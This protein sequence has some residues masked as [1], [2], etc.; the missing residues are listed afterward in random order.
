MRSKWFR[1][2]TT[3]VALRQKGNSIRDIENR[4]K[5]PRSTLSGWLK[6]I[7]LTKIQQHRLERRWIKALVKARKKAVIW[8]NQQKKLRLETARKEALTVLSKISIENK[9][10]IELALAMLY[11]GEGGKTNA[12]VIG[13]SDPLILKFFIYALEEI[14]GLDV[15]KI[16]CELHLRADQNPEEIKAFWSKKLNIPLSSFTST[17]IDLRTTG[18]PTYN[19]YHGVC[20]L[21]C[22]NIAIQRRLVYLGKSFCEKLAK[23]RAVSSVG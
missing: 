10:I 8:H 21:Q 7:N 14:Y 4:L 15:N 19:T 5:I 23:K 12:T 18:R 2:K 17:S 16:K 6:N 11:L 9:S 3:A 20:I 1:L 22:G 13:N